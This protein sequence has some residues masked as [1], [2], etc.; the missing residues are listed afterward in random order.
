MWKIPAREKKKGSPLL[1][2][3]VTKHASYKLSPVAFL[4]NHGHFSKGLLLSVL[5]TA[6]QTGC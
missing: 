1:N 2:N 6:N 5:I 4:H 3:A